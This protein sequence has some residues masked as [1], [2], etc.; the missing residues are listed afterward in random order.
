[1]PINYD[2]KSLNECN[3]KS[4]NLDELNNDKIPP[5]CLD[6]TA[7]PN[8]NFVSGAPDLGWNDDLSNSKTGIGRQ[9][10]CDPM[11]TGKIVNE[12]ENPSP[13][14]I[15]RYA[16]SLRGADEAVM[17]LF[18]NIDVIDEDGKAHRVPII[19][20]TQEK[21]I[22]AIL[23]DNVRKDTSY[24][25]DRIRLPMMAIHSNSIQPNQERYTYSRAKDWMRRFRPDNK[26]GF[27]TDEK[28][29]RDTV[30]GVT[31]GIPVDVSYTLHVW[32]L[33]M[34][35][36]LQITEQIFL[37]FNPVAYIRIRGVTWETIVRLD[38]TSN[39]IN[40][41]PGDQD[42]RVLKYQFEMTA[43]TY[44]AQPISRHKAVL[45]EKIDIYN[46][47]DE[48]K[49]TDVFSRFIEQVDNDRAN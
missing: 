48:D 17:D 32:T 20:G 27:T 5:F 28:Y 29:E 7:P 11:Q 34:E 38:A 49:V 36:L 12:T 40:F 1:M 43:E 46:S 22:A 44:I 24:V 47:V 3:E 39:N 45:K 10:N 14:T 9:A 6:P 8:K 26:P 4:P 21:A 18:K 37:K 25:V 31:R 13:Q 35:D 2:D 30:F 15:Y 19:I 42:L 41:E 16:R 33:Y 23:Q